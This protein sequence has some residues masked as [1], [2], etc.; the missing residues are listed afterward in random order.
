MA[1]IKWEAAES[2]ATAID[3]GANSLADDGRAVSAAIDNA[4]GKYPYMDV[5]IS[6]AAQG[7]ARDAGAH[8][9]VHVLVSLDG[10]NYAFGDG[11]TEPGQASWVGN[12]SLDAATTA[13]RAVLSAVQIPPLLFKLLI[14]NRTGQA[15]AASGNT[16]SYRRY[17]VESA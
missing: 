14:I 3:S 12:V 4:T 10:T 6:L 17:G 9:E 2:I 5:E 13:R 1:T 16:V 15:F 8:V 7:L 11:S